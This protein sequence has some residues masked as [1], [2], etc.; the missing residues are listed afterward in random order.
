MTK[1]SYTRSLIFLFVVASLFAPAQIEKTLLA[2][3]K[4]LEKEKKADYFGAIKHLSDL[5]D[6]STYEFNLRM[7]WLSYKA[8]REKKAVYYYQKAIAMKPN[9]IEPRIGFGYPAYLMEDFTQ[10]IEQD[11]KILSIDPNNKNTNSN[12]ALIYFYNKEYAKA[13]PY[14]QKVAQLYPFD[15]DNNLSLAWSLYYLGKKEEVEKYFN[16]VLLYSPADPSAKEGLE[17]MGKSANTKLIE[18]FA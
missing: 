2:F 13:L 8:G 5:N 4:S 16:N 10:L 1:T 3:S 7:G 17:I 11:K 6:S 15:Y 12:L 9:A 14:F 18:S